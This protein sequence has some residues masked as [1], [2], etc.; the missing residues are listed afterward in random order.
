MALYPRDGDNPAAL[1]ANADAALYRAKHEGRGATRIFTSAMDRQLRERRAIEHDLRSAVENGEFHL[2]Y[3]PQRH[4]DGKIT[5]FEALVRWQHPLRGLVM[6]GEFIPVAEDS[7]S[8]AKIDEWVLKEACRQAA[9]WDDTVRIAVNVSAAQFRREN[10]EHQVRTALR[11]SG[12]PP[13]RLELEITEGV[14]IEDISRASQTLKSLKSLGVMIALDDFGTGYSSL[15]YLQAFPLDRIKIDRSF[16]ASLGSSARSLAIV[17]AVIGLA[18]G[19]NVPVLA[20]GV[21]TNEQLSI[22]MRE[23]CDDLQGYLIG[24]PHPAEMYGE[25]MKSGIDARL[26]TAS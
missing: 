1:L 4:R 19:F 12:L 3:Q 17:R 13:S 18:H 10:L 16:V 7:G 15:S 6:P 8:I 25:Y 21:E 5:G 20:E 9:S 2:E 22:L 11:E 26:K 23:R 24:R 14:L